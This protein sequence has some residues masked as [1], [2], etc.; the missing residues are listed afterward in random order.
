MDAGPVPERAHRLEELGFSGI[1]V[2]CRAFE[3]GGQEL[4]RE[5]AA[6]GYFEVVR[7]ADEHF[8]FVRLRP[9]G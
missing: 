7:S 2:T 5:L 1:L 6:D 4:L 9:R 8:A 3:D